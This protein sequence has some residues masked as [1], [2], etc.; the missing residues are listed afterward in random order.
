MD[1]QKRPDNATARMKREMRSPHLSALLTEMM[2]PL[3]TASA[4]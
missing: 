2:E 3:H 4:Q 1:E